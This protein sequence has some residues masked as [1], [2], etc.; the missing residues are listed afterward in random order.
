[1]TTA[2]S[3][4]STSDERSMAALAH[5]F[6]LI[7]ALIVWAVQKDKSPFVRFQSLQSLAFEAIAILVNMVLM[8]CLFGVMFVGAFGILFASINSASSPDNVDPLFVL[9]MMFPFATFSC[10]IPMTLVYFIVRLI[11]TVSV[12]SGH[13]FRYPWLGKWLEKF[14]EK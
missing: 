5:F 7:A 8:I 10:F 6:G 2:E 4:S 1:M 11:A 3:S 9:P 12:A 14:L 13:D